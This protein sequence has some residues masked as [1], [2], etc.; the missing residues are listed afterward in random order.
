M[1]RKSLGN[2][3]FILFKYFN[4]FIY[5]TNNSFISMNNG[6]HILNDGYLVVIHYTFL[7]HYHS[8]LIYISFVRPSDQ[9]SRLKSL[10]H[11][12]HFIKCTDRHRPYDLV[13]FIFTASSN[14]DICIYSTKLHFD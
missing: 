8:P 13:I 9:K 1:H 5:E 4:Y 12:I 14:F 11:D 7:M 2:Y 10:S 6:N 3:L